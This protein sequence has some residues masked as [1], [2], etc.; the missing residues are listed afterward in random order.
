M[1]MEAPVSGVSGSGGLYCVAAIHNY[2]GPE[3]SFEKSVTPFN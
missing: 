1:I 2:L 3:F